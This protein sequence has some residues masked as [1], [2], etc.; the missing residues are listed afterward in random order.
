MSAAT[1]TPSKR[2]E[3]NRRNGR[4]SK[5]PVTPEGKAK[6]R[7]NALKHGMT[8]ET[9]VILPGEDAEALKA[10]VEAW[11]ADLQ[12][13]SD[14]EDYLVE[15]AAHAAWHLDRCDRAIAA[16]LNEMVRFG[17][18]DRD[19]AESDEAEDLA[20]RLF[21][22]PRGPIA[23]Y[24]HFRGFR[25]KPRISCPDEVDDPLHPAR[26]V[27][28][29]EATL[30]GCGWLLDRW[31]DLRHL[32]EDGL[33]WQAPDRLRAIRL[34]GR[35][36]M[37]ALSDERVLMIY[38]ACDAM[39]PGAPT[40]LE[41]LKTETDAAELAM[42]K[43][44]VQDRGAERKK[45]TSPEAGKAAL[46]ALVEQTMARLVGRLIGHRERRAFQK[47]VQA[48]LLAF[49]D[50][51]EGELMRRYQLAKGRELH[52]ILATYYKVRREA[53]SCDQASVIGEPDGSAPTSYAGPG[54]VDIPISGTQSADVITIETSLC[55][56]AAP[57]PPALPEPA[58]VPAP[59]GETNPNPPD[60]PGGE[61][62]PNPP[63]T[64]PANAAEPVLAAVPPARSD[65]LAVVTAGTDP[66]GPSATTIRGVSGASERRSMS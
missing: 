49:D 41:D 36:P 6:V 2:A 20:R 31:A 27:N 10:R 53:H 44:R 57:A 13:Q 62:N 17:D 23:L 3:A 12:P 45:P 40:S 32:P 66:F 9:L 7:L 19:E 55:D 22:D 29:L 34:L 30:A 63:A 35:Q 54:E 38:L 52:R 33:N 58:P 39:E 11:K 16:R 60:E 48:D 21:W 28:R 65:M 1:E 18:F 26:I 59:V 37:D 64:T 14:L 25:I 47:A 46:L 51:P 4:K 43:Q 42:F 8:A 50:S 24:P 15:R 5:G 56:A 61:T